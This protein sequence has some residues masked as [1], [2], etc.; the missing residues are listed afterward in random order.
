MF[1]LWSSRFTNFGEQ[2]QA[3]IQ[4]QSFKTCQMEIGTRKT[5]FYPFFRKKPGPVARDVA[6]FV[7]RLD[8]GAK[9]GD[10]GRH[11]KSLTLL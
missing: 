2:Q 3:N 1:R 10:V 7:A 6:V 5:T 9:R 11:Q 4:N 8:A